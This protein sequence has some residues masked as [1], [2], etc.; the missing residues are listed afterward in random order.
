MVAE[1][2]S[3]RLWLEMAIV[4]AA[5]TVFGLLLANQGYMQSELRGQPVPWVQVLRHG[6]LEAHA[7][8][9]PQ[10]PAQPARHHGK[11]ELT[12]QRS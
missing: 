12:R 8:F 4:F 1:H 9:G 5:W 11:G 2:R 10:L 6:L 7:D 3:R